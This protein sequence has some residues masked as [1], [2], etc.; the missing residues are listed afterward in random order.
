VST[1]VGRVP[2]RSSDTD[3]PCLACEQDRSFLTG[4]EPRGGPPTSGVRIVDLFSGCGGLSLGIGEGLRRLGRSADYRLAVD[5]EVAPLRAY[6]RNLHPVVSENTDVRNIFGAFRERSTNT[7]R[8]LARR[9]G[10]VDLLIGGP[11]CQGYSP[12]NAHR[13]SAD[14]RRYLYLYMVRAAEVFQ[15]RLILV[16]NVPGVAGHINGVLGATREGLESLGYGTAV[17][18]LRSEHLGVPQRRKRHILIATHSTHTARGILD[19]LP[20]ACQA[21]PVRSIRWAIADLVGKENATA[22]DRPTVSSRLNMTRIAWLFDNGEFDLPNSLRPVCHQGQHRYH[23]MYGRLEWDQPAPTITSGFGSMGQGRFVHPSE[24]R[25]LT[26]H[27]AARLQ[28]FPDG[29]D[30]G[31]TSRSAW[32]SMIGN[33]VPPLMNVPVVRALAPLL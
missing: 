30:F 20:L 18:E 17:R 7:E 16:E 29:F 26:P 13:M 10:Q 3:S 4:D 1:T 5:S 25:T 28:T 12:L 21:H 31:D 6:V 8:D 9:V 15:P 19:E 22:F 24:R 27:E 11:P 14:P 2:N 33:A 32:A 23:S